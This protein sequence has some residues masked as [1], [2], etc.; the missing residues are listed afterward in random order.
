MTWRPL[1]TH[2]Q[3]IERLE[4]IFPREAFGAVL[5]SPLAGWAVGAMVYMDAIV[6]AS[7]DLP[8]DI[9]WVRPTMVL[10]MPQEAYARGDEASR[11]EWTAAATRS[12]R[13]VAELFDSWDIPFDQKYGDNT[14]ETL[15]DEIFPGWLAEG[16]M[17]VRPG[18]KTTS[19]VGRWALTDAFADLFDPALAYD[20]LD[21]SIEDFRTSHM[22]PSGKVKA[23]T[24]RQRSDQVHAVDVTLPNGNVRHLE[25]GEASVILKGV[26]EQWA[27][28][29]LEDPVVLTISE[30]G[31]KIY[32]ADSALIKRLG[33]TVD[34]STLLPDALLADVGMSPPQF[35]IVEAVAS[36][37]P[38]DESR[39]RALL[40]WASEQGIPEVGCNFLTAFGSRNAGPAKKRLKDLATGTFAWYADE[41]LRELS[42]YE[43][44]K[45]PD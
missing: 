26:V 36:D 5:S 25:P 44:K 45:E 2:E 11:T 13:A 6:P 20:L 29:R 9:I 22:S 18:V 12:K 40:Q 8:D 10:W 17:R 7:G 27:L 24:A 38:I 43:L 35:W 30:P 1:P 14:R 16:A 19:P 41:P 21:Q 39:K 42:W 28:V 32:T 4:L 37:G 3:C 34:A 15:R 33:L 23:F 31:D